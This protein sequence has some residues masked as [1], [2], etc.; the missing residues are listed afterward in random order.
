MHLAS[1]GSMKRITPLMTLSWQQWFMPKR[2]G[3]ITSSVIDARFTVT[4]RASSIFSLRSESKATQ[5]A[6]VD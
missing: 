4:T 5:M 1:Y 2:Y 6:R 3:D